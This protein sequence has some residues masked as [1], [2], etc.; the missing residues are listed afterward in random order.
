MRVIKNLTSKLFESLHSV[1]KA[2]KTSLSFVIEALCFGGKLGLTSLARAA[3]SKTTVKHNIKRI[4]RLLNNPRLAKEIPQFCGAVIKTVIPVNSSP[5][6]LVDW[7]LVGKDHCA[8]FASA[9]FEGR[10]VTV[11][12]EV[13]PMKKYAN[14]ELEYAFLDTLNDLLPE[15]VK[16]TLVTDA[17]YLHPWFKKVIA[18]DWYFVG[19]L[20]PRMKV[21]PE[22]GHKTSVK[23]LEHFT[24]KTATDIGKCTVTIS[25]PL[26]YRVIQG[27]RYRRNPKRS[28]KSRPFTGYGRGSHQARRRAQTAWVLATNHNKLSADH[29]VS[30]YALRMSI[31]EQFRDFKNARFGWAFRECRTS[32]KARYSILL[33]IGSIGHLI[34][35]LV[36]A[37]AEKKKLHERFSSRSNPKSRVLS[38]F[39]LAK[40]L[41]RFHYRFEVSWSDINSAIYS[42]SD[43]F[44]L[45]IKTGDT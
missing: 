11:Y 16:P 18:L 21:F 42:L 6:L 22:K 31:E 5:V 13:H 12:F 7:T 39:F 26:K 3:Y 36:G 40:E 14:R 15:G 24:K 2:R 35:L 44:I 1:H 37:I 27:K 4:D 45:K 32:S 9:P 8:L 33:L 29:I 17:G 43:Y 41:L 30:L 10:A 28:A 38:L 25:N 34:M 23:A 20:N 19:R